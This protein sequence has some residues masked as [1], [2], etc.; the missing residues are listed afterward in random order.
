[1][2]RLHIAALASLAYYWQRPWEY[3]S[4]SFPAF[5]HLHTNFTY[6]YVQKESWKRSANKSTLLQNS[7]VR[8]LAAIID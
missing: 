3:Q 8:H 1:M 4:V 2:L 6:S 5:S 7:T